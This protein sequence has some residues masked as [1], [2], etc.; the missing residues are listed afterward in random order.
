VLDSLQRTS[1]L[2]GPLGDAVAGN[3][4]TKSLPMILNVGKRGRG[5]LP[6]TLSLGGDLA[7][8]GDTLL[9]I[10]AQQRSFESAVKYDPR[11]AQTRKHAPNAKYRGRLAVYRRMTGGSV[12]EAANPACFTRPG[13][14][15]H[16]DRRRFS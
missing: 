11:L 16:D 4:T 2:L 15:R 7:D 8:A 3:Y 14:G 10:L 5:R 9:K 1:I 6:L 12:G 13:R